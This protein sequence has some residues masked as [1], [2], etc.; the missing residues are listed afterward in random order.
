MGIAGL[1]GREMEL[2]TLVA[3]LGLRPCSQSG[4]SGRS[5]Q[6]SGAVCNLCVLEGSN[7]K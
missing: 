4:L 3:F 1:L 6:R 5:L 2:R 7:K